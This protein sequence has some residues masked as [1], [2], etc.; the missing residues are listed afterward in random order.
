MP[1]PY[2]SCDRRTLDFGGCRCPAFHL[3]G[4]AAATG[5]VC[6]LAPD[7]RLVT[8]ARRAAVAPGPSPLEYRAANPVR[9]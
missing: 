9:R 8:D 5:P 1:A 3:T 6:P 4:N 2:R 7:H